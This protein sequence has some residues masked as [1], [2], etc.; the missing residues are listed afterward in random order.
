MIGFKH[1]I[2]SLLLVTFA[3]MAVAQ[4]NTNSPYTRYGYGDLADPSFG[5]SK[6]M[7]GAAYGL[8]DGLQIN[9]LNPASYTAVDSLTLLFDGGFTLQNTNLSFKGTRLNA[10]N[11]SFDY[12]AMQFRLRRGVGMSMGLLP[13]SNVGYNLSQSTTTATATE[14][15]STRV[16]SG[17]GGLHQIYVGLAAAPIKNLSVG[18]NIS[19]LWGETNRTAAIYYASYASA[20]SFSEL[21]HM[22]L[23]DYKLD[24]GAQY[25]H[26]FGSKHVATLG[27]V[28]SPQQNLN[29]NTYVQT[30]ASSVVS[31][32]TTVVTGIPNSFGAGL[33]YVYD[34]R[35][36]VSLDYNLQ[37]WASVSY[38]NSKDAFYDQTKIS[39]GAEYLPNRVGRSYLSHVRY[40]FGGYYTTPYYK[41]ENSD[42]P[43]VRE[44]GVSAGVGLPLPRS[45]SMLSLTAQ[46]VRV[47]AL[48]PEMAVSENRFKLSVGFTFNER[49]FFKRKVN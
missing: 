37:Q 46:F 23:Y 22:S 48:N 9:P 14:P 41:L 35:L 32:D 12:L 13:Y 44:Y 8:R 47:D 17:D 5:N 6:A 31:R 10:K 1:T 49:W 25:T 45:R 27:V 30:T 26:A 16:F 33:T 39:L 28:F 38:M 15:A 7:G 36:T 29:N 20:Y 19:F 24:F 43:A 21:T 3:G 18:A 34:K 40:R 4:N 11:S 2:C 42:D